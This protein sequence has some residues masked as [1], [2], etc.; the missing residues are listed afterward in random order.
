METL[1]KKHGLKREECLMVGN[2]AESD[3]AVAKKCGVDGLLV[4]DG[5]FPKEPFA[6]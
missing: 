6:L 3:L 4:S 5:R 2:E 1:L